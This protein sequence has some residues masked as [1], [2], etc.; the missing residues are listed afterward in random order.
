MSNN[1]YFQLQFVKGNR[2]VTGSVLQL[3]PSKSTGDL[4]ITLAP[5]MGY[6][7]NL[8]KFDYK[9]FLIYQN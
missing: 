8:P 6:E 4:L 1:V 5:Q 3:A 7:N 9:Q 2:N